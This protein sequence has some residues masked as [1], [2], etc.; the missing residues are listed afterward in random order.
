MHAFAQYGNSNG[1]LDNPID[2]GLGG[3]GGDFGYLGRPIKGT[4]D[5]DYKI[6]NG[7]KRMGVD[8]VFVGHEHCNSISIVYDG[9]RLQYGQKSST[10]DRS[11]FEQSDG[12]YAGATFG[13]LPVVG[14][15]LIPLAED[16]S[17]TEPC[18]I[19]YEA[20]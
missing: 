15:T 6:W 13:D 19:L 16:G 14:G 3:Y 12:S 17:I 20:E 2:L 7:F 5:Q 9:I 4:W 11:N 18:I 10:Y 1:D 8:S